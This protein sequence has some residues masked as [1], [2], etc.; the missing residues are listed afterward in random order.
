MNKLF[1]KIAS[2]F[3]GIAMA[4]GVGVALGVDSKAEPVRA[5]VGE[6]VYT[7]DG[8][9]TATGNAYATASTLTQNSIGWK[10]VA[11]T[12]QNPWRFGGKGI[13]NQDR[14]AYSTTALSDNI[15]KIEVSSGGTA[16]NLTV[17]SLT[18][19][20]H[21]TA[22]DA[23]NGTNA[24]ATKNVS[25]DIVSKVVEFTKADSTSWAGK[26]FRIVYNVTRT[27]TSSN[28][29]V[30]FNYAKF[31][32]EQSADTPNIT[33]SPASLS[34][35]STDTGKDVT[36][37]PNDVFEGTPTVSVEGTPSYVTSSVNG[38]VVTFTPKAVGSETVT[39][40]ATYNSQVATATLDVEVLDAHGRTPDDPFSVADVISLI[41]ED[42]SK[43][44]ENVYVTGIICQIDSFN[45]KYGSITYWIS[46]DGKTDTKFEAYS[47]LG[48]DS[49]KFSSI[50]D[51]EVG[52]TV[53]LCGNAK[54][55]SSTSVY[56][57]DYNN[58]QVSYV[59]PSKALSSIEL[60]GTYKTSFEVGDTFDHEGLVVTAHYDNGATKDVSE[61]V[62]FSGFDS[63]EVV[64]SQTITVSYTED[65]VT[66]TADYTVEIKAVTV[67]HTI[68][69]NDGGH[70]TGTMAD[71]KVSDGDDYPLPANGFTPESGWEFDSW[72]VGGTRRQ[73]GF[74]VENI[75]EDMVFIAMWEEV[76]ELV[77]ELTYDFIGITGTSYTGWSDKA[78]TS[79]TVYAGQS[80]GGNTSI[81]LRSQS[82]AGIVSTA[83]VGTVAKVVVTWNSNTMDG[84]T[85]DIY[86]KDAAYDSAADLYDAEKQ[87]TS[88]GSVA[89]GTST[90]LVVS[91]DYPYVGFVSN[92]GA[93]YIDKIEITW[94]TEKKTLESIDLSGDYQTIFE[95]GDD[96]NYDGL[97]VT[98]N[99]DNDTHQTVTP[100]SVSTPDM[101]TTGDKEV[102]VS[103]T[104][105][106][107]TKTAS[108]DITV[109]A[110]TTKYTISFNVGLHGSG[111]MEDVKVSEGDDY[112]L[113][114]NGFTPDTG[115][116]FDC[117]AVGGNRRDPGYIIE[118]VNE[119]VEVIAMWA[120]T[121]KATYKK[122][123]T[124]L[125]DYSGEYLIVYE[126]D[127]THQAVAFNGSLTSL[128]VANS[129]VNVGISND[130][131]LLNEDYSFTVAKK[132]GGYSIKS[133]SGLYIGKTAYANGLDSDATD[134]YTNGISYS[135]DGGLVI[136]GEG[137]SATD[138]PVTL[139]YNY[140]NDQLRYRFYKSG[141][142]AVSLYM[143]VDPAEELGLELLNKT[144][145]D[146]AAY[147]DGSSSYDEYKT[148]MET[149]W[150]DLSTMYDNIEDPSKLV[151]TSAKE[152]GTMLEEA[153]A[154]YDFLTVKYQLDNF[155]AGRKPAG[156][157]TPV[158][159]PTKNS[160]TAIIIVTIIA[161]TS[162]SA[163]GALL[164]IKRRKS[165]TK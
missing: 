24:V 113:P 143:R 111:T 99:F 139:R 49:A 3:V 45:D 33:L 76:S 31:Y 162:V 165:I 144:Y 12:E 64:A 23:E 159:V 58:Y 95:T 140:A 84:R 47:G 57:Y 55:Y 141:Q 112:P 40:K 14:A 150:S 117:W 2:T 56:E 43:I 29:Y 98:A 79:G 134:K 59:A 17:N 153:M 110:P 77:D 122:V 97:I 53:V 115:W 102:V 9:I 81:Q 8:T 118:D 132:E 126:G 30:S 80:A 149:I 145:E 62:S 108:Y 91:G 156:A 71:V 74:V 82:P 103:Y 137:T 147:V 39:V 160:D 21:S 10:V 1:T 88:L 148:K 67:K 38:L 114:S 61:S 94:S 152:D 127:A 93:M 68:S 120:E 86:G 109:N 125:L 163:I 26:F 18:I 89:K 5:D 32:K 96:F 44:H 13:T 66:K 70:G 11:N 48:I 37:T 27:S 34:F 65:E 46:D 50:D 161:I 25:S 73:P 60:S 54:Y 142:Q 157:V 136:S 146:C 16:S 41:D 164:V 155:I 19:S 119:D 78:G 105:E 123:E 101:S 121:E 104:Y 36:V 133:A 42:T 138:G 135:S 158:I 7:L 28:G 52:A 72:S 107:V 63:S 116:K 106:E 4:V 151:S 87:G 83:S 128:D 129:G 154:R 92:S 20:V 35:L 75:T 15:V 124:E 90:Q 131:I 130:K 69:F 22:S 6:L 85:L 51:I 100:T